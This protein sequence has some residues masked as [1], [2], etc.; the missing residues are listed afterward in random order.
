MPILTLMSERKVLY[1]WNKVRAYTKRVQEALTTRLDLMHERMRRLE[2]MIHI[3]MELAQVIRQ[4]QLNMDIAWKQRIEFTEARVDSMDGRVDVMEQQAVVMERRAD[5]LRAD[6]LQER[7]DA[8]Q[9]RSR[10]FENTAARLQ[11]RI[12][13]LEETVAMFLSANEDPMEQAD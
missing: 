13:L 11:H 10:R 7:V 2:H 9:Q 3:V 8:L 12:D 5:A 1:L 4:A 6:A